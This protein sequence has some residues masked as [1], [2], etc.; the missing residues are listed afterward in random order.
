MDIPIPASEFGQVFFTVLQHRCSNPSAP[1]LSNWWG[2]NYPQI[3]DVIDS[4]WK[5]FLSFIQEKCRKEW[6]HTAV[7]STNR[8]TYRRIG[9]HRAGKAMHASSGWAL[10]VPASARTICAQHG[11]SRRIPMNNF[12]KLISNCWTVFELN[13]TF[14]DTWHMKL[15]II[16]YKIREQPLLTVQ[17]S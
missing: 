15:M 7:S 12:E 11:S 6:N 4:I 3:S 8:S 9:I 13:R 10:P 1:F 16:F 14:I 5:Y 2:E 17:H